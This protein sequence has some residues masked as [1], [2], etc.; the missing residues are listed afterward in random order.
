MSDGVNKKSYYLVA[1][2]GCSDGSDVLTYDTVDQKR[3][4][5]DLAC[6]TADLTHDTAGGL[7]LV[8]ALNNLATISNNSI[9]Y[10]C[11]QLINKLLVILS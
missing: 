11:E 9:A 6:D 1:A 7:A 3:D 5:A 4:I 8:R 2:Q 10:K